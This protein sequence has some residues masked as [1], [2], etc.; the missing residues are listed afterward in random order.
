MIDVSKQIA[1]WRR[2]AD[3]DWQAA[4]LLMEKNHVRHG[5]FF[6]NLA[7]EKILKAHVCKHT[8][9][10][11]PKIHPLLRLLEI[12][13]LALTEDQRLFLA[14]FDRY[15]ME[16]RYPENLPDLPPFE[17]VKNDFSKA[18]ELLEWLKNQL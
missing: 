7:L 18:R 12:S 6:A 10:L 15:Q 3:E 9:N 16:G 4:Q 5:L 2:S 17:A 8:N 14:K 13:E 1:Y 11:A